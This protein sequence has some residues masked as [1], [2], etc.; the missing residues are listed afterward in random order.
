MIFLRV[1]GLVE[2]QQVDLT[3]WYKRMHEALI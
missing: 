1:M 3:D 2:Y